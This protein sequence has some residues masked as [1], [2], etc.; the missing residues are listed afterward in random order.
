M[1]YGWLL[2]WIDYGFG[3]L[4]LLRFL[5]CGQVGLLALSMVCLMVWIDGACL[6]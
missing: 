1:L 4:R 6:I 5:G 3:L 2:L